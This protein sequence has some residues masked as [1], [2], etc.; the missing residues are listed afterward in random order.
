[1]I[2][3]KSPQNKLNEC[4]IDSKSYNHQLSSVA[5]LDRVTHSSMFKYEMLFTNLLI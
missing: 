5:N 3:M 2:I 4:S 1:M